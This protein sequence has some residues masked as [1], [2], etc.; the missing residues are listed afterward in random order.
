M[1]QTVRVVVAAVGGLAVLSSMVLAFA[2]AG[3][4]P[5]WLAPSVLTSGV[6]VLVGGWITL[7]NTIA[8]FIYVS[9]DHQARN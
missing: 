4:H 7:S 2:P 5:V 3:A 9:Y 6:A 8:K 1:L